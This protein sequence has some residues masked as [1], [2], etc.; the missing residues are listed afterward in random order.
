[1]RLHIGQS[2]L[3]FQ[4]QYVISMESLVPKAS[5]LVVTFEFDGQNG[6]IKHF[7]HSLGP[8]LYGNLRHSPTYITWS[9][10]HRGGFFVSVDVPSMLHTRIFT[11]VRAWCVV[12]KKKT[13]QMSTRIKSKLIVVWRVYR[14]VPWRH[15]NIG[16]KSWFSILAQ[17][18]S[19]KVLEA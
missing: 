10:P 3:H 13:R 18:N 2:P 7:G 16:T 11:F 17:S 4:E 9:L 12:W 8:V 19:G 1:M 15:I 14:R 6:G 5:Q